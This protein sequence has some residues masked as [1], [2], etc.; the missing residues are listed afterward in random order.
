MSVFYTGNSG[1]SSGEHLDARL[2]DP[3]RKQYLDLKAPQNRSYLNLLVSGDK[4]VLGRFPITSDYG[5]RNTGIPGASTFH[6]G[7]DFGTPAGTPVA[8]KGGWWKE[9]RFD[10]NGGGHVGVFGLK[11]AAGEELEFHLLHGD[12]RN[13]KA[14]RGQ[15]P[16]ADPGQTLAAAGTPVVLESVTEAPALPAP[17]DWRQAAS[18]PRRVSDP[19]NPGYWQRQ[20]IREWASANPALAAAE[21]L[22]RGGDAAWLD[23]PAATA[24]KPEDRGAM[25]GVQLGGLTLDPEALR[26][27][28]WV[29]P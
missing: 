7:V 19:A 28:G 17:P 5:P 25:G 20:D 16:L 11:N 22:K 23:A 3:R 21:L 27:L 12:P 4:P 13:A 2:W 10:K 8:V 26:K 24:P 18:A 9:S 6:R 15:G 14:P 1:I 29:A